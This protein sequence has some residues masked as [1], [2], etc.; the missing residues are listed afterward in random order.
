MESK[1]FLS[2]KLNEE[3]LFYFKKT[4][5]FESKTFNHILIRWSDDSKMLEDHRYVLINRLIP[6]AKKLK[7]LDMAAGCGSFV[8]QG[9]LNGYDT[10]GV[11]PEEWKQQLI[12]IKFE[13]HN[14]PKEWR[15]R[16][17]RGTGEALPFDNE[18]FDMFDSWQTIEHVQDEEKCIKELYRVL[19][20]GGCGILRGP[21]Y[22][23]FYEGH[24][25][26]LWFPLLNPKSKFAK[27]YAG[28]IRKRPLAGLD[29]FHP[30]NPFKI[31][32]YAKEAGFKIVDIKR[33]QIYDAAKRIMPLL[34]KKIFKPVLFCIYEVWDLYWFFK[35]ACTCT[36]H[37][38]ISYLL[39]K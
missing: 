31:R 5:D 34:N 21:D 13:E 18:E 15:N 36:N 39:I 30:V 26:M 2:E 9:L 4:D 24:Y 16:I 17:K 19:K 35:K 6:D 32:K 12:D 3:V 38:T 33:K 11:E 1:D 20:K 27:W 22:I 29:T 10:Y 23:C 37:A 28:K 7:I 8:I 14:Y 25:R